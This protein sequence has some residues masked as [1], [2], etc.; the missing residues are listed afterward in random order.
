[1]AGFECAVDV[2]TWLDATFVY[3][4]IKPTALSSLLLELLWLMMMAADWLMATMDNE[5][6]QLLPGSCLNPRFA[7]SKGPI[8]LKQGVWLTAACTCFMNLWNPYSVIARLII[9]QSHVQSD[10]IPFPPRP[11]PSE[12]NTLHFPL[13]NITFY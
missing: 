4:G 6:Y 1:M 12:T 11:R 10:H 8:C 9:L 2:I 7:Q 3:S 5:A 13:S